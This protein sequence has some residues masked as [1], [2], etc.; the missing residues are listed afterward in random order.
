MR[1][2]LFQNIFVPIPCG[3]KVQFL[4]VLRSQTAQKFVK[5]KH[6]EENVAILFASYACLLVSKHFL[7][8][9]TAFAV[10]FCRV[11]ELYFQVQHLKKKEKVHIISGT[12]G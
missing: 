3:N 9:K 5:A 1:V 12:I 10:F 6:D 2:Y 7:P 8:K 11:G 4:H